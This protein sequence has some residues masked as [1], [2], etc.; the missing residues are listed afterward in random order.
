MINFRE[1][2]LS[3]R[4]WIEPIFLKAGLMACEYTFVNNFIWSG[5]YNLEIAY[6]D[7]F[8]CTR[9]GLSEVE[10]GFPIGEGNLK[11]VIELLIEDANVRKEPFVMHAL[12]SEHVTM[13]DLLMPGQFEYSTLR[14]ECDYIYASEKLAKLAGKKLHGKRNHIA[15][16][17]DN[18][19]WKYET[20]NEDNIKDCIEMNTKWCESNQCL[21]NITLQHESCAVKKSFHNFQELKLIGGLLRLDGEVVAFTI[22]EPLNNNTFVVHVEKAFSEIQGAYPMINQQFV[23][24]ECQEFEF[25]NREEDMGEEGLRKAKMSYYPELLLDK[26]H[27]VYKN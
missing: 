15:R 16:F 4:E 25:V 9:S 19:D 1:I 17:Q 14:D 10:Y 7:G 13:L 23:L 27:A 6:V 3:D 12:L 18:L 22:G 24:H 21:E 2:E 11:A 8:Y 20:I 26:Y 5:Q